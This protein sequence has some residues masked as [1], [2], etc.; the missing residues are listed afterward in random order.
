M[1]DTQPRNPVILFKDLQKHFRK[2]SNMERKKDQTVKNEP[3]G[4]SKKRSYNNLLILV[5]GQSSFET[6]HGPSCLEL[7]RLINFSL[8]SL[9]V[10]PKIIVVVSSRIFY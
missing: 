1:F 6:F 2:G 5:V 3:K 10:M 4:K 8:S 9:S 7:I